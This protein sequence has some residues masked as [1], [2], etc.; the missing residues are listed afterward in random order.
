MQDCHS[1]LTQT[2]LFLVLNATPFKH[3]SIALSRKWL[4]LTSA[5]KVFHCSSGLALPQIIPPLCS[6]HNSKLNCMDDQDRL[7]LAASTIVSNAEDFSKMREAAKVGSLYSTLDT[8]SCMW[9]VWRY[10]AH[11]ANI[12]K[13]NMEKL[14]LNK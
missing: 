13:S 2:I 6:L 3:Y 14:V 5:C 10:M 12:Y 1:T 4:K 9:K 7:P 11:P 8:C